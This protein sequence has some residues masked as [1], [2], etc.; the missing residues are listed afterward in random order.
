[1]FV[2]VSVRFFRL[3]FTSLFILGLTFFVFPINTLSKPNGIPPFS[4]TLLP[5]FEHFSLFHPLSYL[6]PPFI[7]DSRV[8]DIFNVR[9]PYIYINVLLQ[10]SSRKNNPPSPTRIRSYLTSDQKYFVLDL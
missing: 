4:P 1:M 9:I 6:S 8:H 5:N 2:F 3:C 10:E 7:P